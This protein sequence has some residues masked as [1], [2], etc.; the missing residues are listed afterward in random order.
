MP[1]TPVVRGLLGEA[2]LVRPEV[3]ADDLEARLEGRGVD[4]HPLDGAG[5]GP[6]AAGDL[7]ALEGRAGRRGGGEQPVPV[8]QHDLG[9]GADVDDQGHLVDEMRRLGEDD[10]GGIG[11]DMAGDAGQHVD[12]GVG[13]DASRSISLAQSVIASSVASA[14]GAPPSSVGSMPSSR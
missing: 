9:I 5:R 3:G 13:M 6:L 11:A 7:R 12:P 1:V 2:R 4:A 14:K 8:A 10:A